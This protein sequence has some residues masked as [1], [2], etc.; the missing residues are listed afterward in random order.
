MAALIP[1]G[2]TI[3]NSTSLIHPVPICSMTPI[4]E[5]V[6]DCGFGAT[7][8]CAD[9]TMGS[10]D[11]NAVRH[12]LFTLHHHHR[13]YHRNRNRR[14]L[15]ASWSSSS[16]SS[17]QSSSWSSPCTRVHGGQLTR[18]CRQSFGRSRHGGGGGGGWG[19]RERKNESEPAVDTSTLARNLARK[20]G[21]SWYSTQEAGMC[22]ER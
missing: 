10:E 15:S 5:Y 21:G 2:V 6:C 12:P 9:S 7:V 22:N 16:S 11:V 14:C 4:P 19:D 13:H 8:A 1:G 3:S 20:L 17:S 18:A